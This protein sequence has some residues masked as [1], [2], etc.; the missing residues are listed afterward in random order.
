MAVKARLPLKNET[1]VCPRHRQSSPP[2]CPR[3]PG[4]KL[5]CEALTSVPARTLSRAK[6]NPDSSSLI[7]FLQLFEAII[8]NS[9][10]FCGHII[11]W[12]IVQ[13][14]KIAKLILCVV[15]VESLAAQTPRSCS[16]SSL[17]TAGKA[18]LRGASPNTGWRNRAEFGLWCLLSHVPHK[19]AKIFFSHFHL[20]SFYLRESLAFVRS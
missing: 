13:W 5:H 18:L 8:T 4:H 2:A 16:P 14:S 1:F 7:Q 17:V 9:A 11:K 12:I 3:S 20:K 15:R 10:T 6:G 19:L